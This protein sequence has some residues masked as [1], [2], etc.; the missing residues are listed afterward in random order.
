MKRLSIF[1][2]MVALIAGMVGCEPTCSCSPPLQYDLIIDSTTGGSVSTPGVGGFTYDAGTVVSLVAEAEECYEFVN[3]TGDTV[4]DPNSAT[5]TITMDGAKTV[6]ANFALLSYD[7]TADSTDGGEVIT[8]G[9]GTS[10]YECGTVVGLVAEAEEG[11][12]FVNWTGDVD[13]I[14]NI[15]APTTTI[16]MNGDYSITANFEQIPPGQFILTTSSTAGG[17]VTTPGEGTFPY[18]QGTEVDVVAVADDCYE[19]VNWTGDVGTIANDEAAS[20]AIIM[21]GNYVITANFAVL[22]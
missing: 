13:T 3:W 14:A 11:Y 22:S 18:D 16:T 19:F 5:T 8:P 7:L 2:I 10:T 15:N 17:S 20:T 12:Y 1:L 6:T 9:E 4:A 21:N